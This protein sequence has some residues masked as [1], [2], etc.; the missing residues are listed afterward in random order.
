MPP[1]GH[2]HMSVVQ[3][4]R[5]TKAEYEH[6]AAFRYSLRRFL[7]FSEEAVRPLGIEPQQHQ[8]LLAVE[9]FP[10]DGDVTLGELAEQLQIKPHSAVGLVNRMAEQGLMIRKSAKDDRRKVLVSVTRQGKE[11]LERLS[12]AHRQEL[13]RIGGRLR[14]QL[15]SLCADE[16]C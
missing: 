9:G 6:L 8:A 2:L 11:L 14:E 1:E 12:E 10:G 4:K 3:P 15:E 13:R 16:P 5:M 7:R